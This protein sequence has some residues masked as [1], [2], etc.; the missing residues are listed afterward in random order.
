MC[1]IVAIYASM[2]NNDD[3][4]KAILDAGKKI[5]HRGPDWNGVRI[6]PKGIAIE[7]ER[8]AIIDPESGAQPLVSNDGTITLAVNGEVYNYKELMATLQT[9]YTFKTKSDCE[10]IIP[11][12]KQHGTAFLRH[13]RGMFSFVLYDSAKDVLI[14]ARDHMGITPLYYGYGADGSVWFASEMKALE[15]FETAVTKRMMSDVPWGVLLSGGLDSSLVASIASRH[16][17]KLFAAGADTEW[18]P[19]LHSFTIGLDNSP[20]LAAAKEVAK[21]LGTIHH[22]YTYTIQEGIDAVSDVIYHLET[23]DVTTIRASTPMFLMSRKIK[24]MGIKMVLSGEGAD[25]VFGGYLYFHKA[26]HAQALH[27]ET[28]LHQFDCLR[29]NKSTS[30][31]GVEARVPFLDADFLDV[32]MNLDSTEKMKEQFS[33]G[34]G[35]GWIDALKDW[36]DREISDR[37]MKHAEL[38]FPYNTPQTKEAYLYRRMADDD[39]V[40][41]EECADEF[42]RSFFMHKTTGETTWELPSSSDKTVD[43]SGD[44]VL[45]AT[46]VSRLDRIRSQLL[47]LGDDNTV[48]R[49]TAVNGDGGEEDEEWVHSFDPILRQAYYYECH[50]GSITTHPPRVFRDEDPLFTVLLVIQCAFRCALARMRVRRTR[51]HGGTDGVPTSEEGGVVEPE[52]AD[53]Q[54]AA[55]DGEAG[56]EEPVAAEGPLL[57]ENDE[58]R[59]LQPPPQQP[60]RLTASTP[61]LSRLVEAKKPVTKVCVQC[62]NT[63][64]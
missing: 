34:V 52:V 48:K 46:T 61:V 37:Q 58:P 19:R 11:L 15:A 51:Q 2:L 5:R 39:D 33:D 29:A 57:Q 12:Y 62:T 55:V 25:E 28:G 50:H 27:D 1:G 36:A 54:D 40:E 7:H 30:A 18:S 56:D 23:Y 38:L 44:F 63:S 13:L 49:M 35:Y 43:E 47:L 32:A 64:R 21:S 17:K 53:V 41:W 42:G 3:L 26:P 8:L 31:W 22:S 20:D 45:D 14:A 24:A 9:P 60:T 16:Q 6:L 4:R 59:A 10:V